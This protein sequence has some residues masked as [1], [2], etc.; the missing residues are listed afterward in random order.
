[1]RSFRWGPGAAIFLEVDNTI[2][3][4]LIEAEVVVD[5]GVNDVEVR[6]VD[7]EGGVLHPRHVVERVAFARVSRRPVAPRPPPGNGGADVPPLDFGDSANPGPDYV[8]AWRR[9]GWRSGGG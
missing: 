9:R 1:M 6:Y 5:D 8:E 4:A 2:G 7:P 3:T